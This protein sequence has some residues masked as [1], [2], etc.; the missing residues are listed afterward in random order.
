MNVAPLSIIQARLGSTR[1]EKKM[2][3]EVGG[4]SL[5]R[6]AWDVSVEAFGEKNVVFA[7]PSNEKSAALLMAAIKLIPHVNVFQWDGPEDDVLGRFWHCAHRYRWHPDSVIVRVTPDDPF[8]DS[9]MMLRVANGERLPV[10]QGA[11]AFTLAMLDQAYYKITE[12]REHLGMIFFPTRPPPPPPGIWSIDTADDLAAANL[13]WAE[14]TLRSATTYRRAADD[15]ARGPGDL[16][17]P[18]MGELHDTYT[19]PL[20]GL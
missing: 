20:E 16:S 2:L 4:R 5:I 13:Q 8:K 12:E 6:R 11:E 1:L 19:D 17:D 9:R 3:L 7:V 10:E 18:Q 15:A 14:E